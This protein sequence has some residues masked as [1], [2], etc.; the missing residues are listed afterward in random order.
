[1]ELDRDILQYSLSDIN[2]KHDHHK[3]KYDD[4][5]EIIL[6]KTNL[7]INEQKKNQTKL[8]AELENV[9][10]ASSKFEPNIEAMK[11]CQEILIKYFLN[12]TIK[13]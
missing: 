11:N 6:G 13:N 9:G 2:T 10:L 3:E 4:D 5:Q 12:K 8:I 1:M 7:R